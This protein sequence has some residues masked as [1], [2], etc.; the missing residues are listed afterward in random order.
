MLKKRPKKPRRQKKLFQIF[1]SILVSIFIGFL[2]ISNFRII[3][4]KEKLKAE[5]QLLK[6]KIFSLKKEKNKLEAAISQIQKESY[7][8]EK[9]R[10]EGYLK[11]GENLVVFLPPKSFEK[12]EISK[13]EKIP[14]SFLEKIKALFQEIRE[15][16]K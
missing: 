11:K 7:W 9:I 15:Q 2:S 12:K 5:N 3:Q 13:E 1:F 6:E 10:E 16:L 4:K 14:K 8:E